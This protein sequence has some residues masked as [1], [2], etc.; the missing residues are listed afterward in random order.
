MS[1]EEYR[2]LKALC[3]ANGSRSVSE[4][5]RVAIQKLL[6]GCEEPGDRALTARLAEFDGRLTLLDH[7]V[8]RLSR[9]LEVSGRG[10]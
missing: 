3:A 10:D 5:A 2:S 1:D 9:L 6:D 8:A 4:L 7:E